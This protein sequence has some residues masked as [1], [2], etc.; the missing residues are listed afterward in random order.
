M[1]HSFPRQQMLALNKCNSAEEGTPSLSATLTWTVID[2]KDKL[3]T[4]LSWEP[5][6]RFKV[7]VKRLE[8]SDTKVI[9]TDFHFKGMWTKTKG[10]GLQNYHHNL[11]LALCVIL[12]PF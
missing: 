12:E 6:L 7:D 11:S 1:K 9:V 4:A 8:A 3:P 2:K 10:G 5:D